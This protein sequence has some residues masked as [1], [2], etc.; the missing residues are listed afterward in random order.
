[1]SSDRLVRSR[2]KRIALPR[3]GSAEGERDLAYASHEVGHVEQG[4]DPAPGPAADPVAGAREGDQGGSG[5]GL[6]GV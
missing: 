2:R 3:V 1:M 5:W 6:A 4:S